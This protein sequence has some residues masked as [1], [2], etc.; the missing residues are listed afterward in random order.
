MEAKDGY[1]IFKNGKKIYC[2]RGIVG[3]ALYPDEYSGKITYGYDGGIRTV[4][5]PGYHPE[6][7]DIIET[8]TEEDCIELATHMVGAWINV[9]TQAIDRRIKRGP[10]EE[11]KAEKN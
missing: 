3:L 7:D 2:N 1:L 5:D 6:Y 11:P 8:L 4:L 10:E 9:L